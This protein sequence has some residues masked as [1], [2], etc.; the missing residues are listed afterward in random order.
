MNEPKRTRLA[1]L[2]EINKELKTP[3]AK[4]EPLFMAYHR[5]EIDQVTY[6]TQFHEASQEFRTTQHK[7]RAAADR[8]NRENGVNFIEAM[9]S[10]NVNSPLMVDPYSAGEDIDHYNW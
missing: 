7:F 4:M 3:R 5:K 10:R 8:W 1:D 2:L 9:G 6:A